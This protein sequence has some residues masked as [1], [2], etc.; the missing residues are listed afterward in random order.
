MVTFIIPHEVM[1]V[2]QTVIDD[3]PVVLPVVKVIIE[4]DMLVC[5]TPLFWLELLI[6]E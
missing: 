5:M 4:P 2:V 1:L 3:E 6:T